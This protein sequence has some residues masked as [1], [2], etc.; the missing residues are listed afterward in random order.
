MGKATRHTAPTGAE[1]PRVDDLYMPGTSMMLGGNL[2]VQGGLDV[3][4]P[5]VG[6]LLGGGQEIFDVAV[7]ANFL[8]TSTSFVTVPGGSAQFVIP[9]APFRLFG[10]VPVTVET[11]GESAEMRLYNV[12][13]DEQIDWDFARATVAGQSFK[14]WLSARIPAPTWTPT[15]GAT[16]T[17]AMQIR[18]TVATSDVAVIVDFGGPFQLCQMQAVTCGGEGG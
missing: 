8:T 2:R 16:K 13:D 9:D 3:V 6:S 17:V 4:G 5:G 10:S 11:L 12:E 15:V 18:T 7:S 14:Q 1:A